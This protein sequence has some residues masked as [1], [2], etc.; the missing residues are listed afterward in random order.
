[1]VRIAVIGYGYWGKNLVRNFYSVPNGSLAMVIDQDATRLH[2]LQ[3]L[4]PQVAVS[5]SP[6]EA[7]KNKT[8]DAIVIAT[9]V[10]THFELAKEALLHDKHVLVEK[11][12]TASPTEAQMLIELALAKGK[13]LMPDHTF[14]YTGA[15]QKMKE[16]VAQGTVG[17]IQ[18]I[19][20]TRIN[21]GLFQPDLNVLWDLAPHD[22]SIC[23]YLIDEMPY[24]V[25]ATGISHTRNG[26]ENLAYLTLNYQSN[27][28]AHFSCSWSSPVKVRNML[29]GGD[30]KMILY[31]D[32]E[33]T[34]KVKVYDAGYDLKTEED[35]TKILV[36]YRVG[37]IYVPK[38]DNTEALASLARDFVQCILHAQTPRSHAELGLRVVQILEA[39]QKSIKQQGKE[40]MLWQSI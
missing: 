18:Y 19:D 15:V 7:L 14:L 3:Q 11:P 35:K 23:D 1:M 33:T 5:T 29:I 2:A 39:A 34:E 12:M 22:L 32:L 27:R 31:N 13:L 21:L 37:D 6:A 36:D 40:I 10:S 28:I 25:Q 38:L 8:I 4:Y 9:P 20:S 30:K 16:L 26:I 17:K 24:S